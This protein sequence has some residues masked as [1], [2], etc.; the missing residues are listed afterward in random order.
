MWLWVEAIS[1]PRF[2]LHMFRSYSRYTILWRAGCHIERGKPYITRGR[3]V[4]FL[5]DM[6]LLWPLHVCTN[7]NSA[8]QMPRARRS[9]ATS[10]TMYSGNNLYAR[11]HRRYWAESHLHL[12]EKYD[13]DL[14]TQ[15]IYALCI[16]LFLAFAGG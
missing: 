3:S 7:G 10:R 14:N 6:T 13:H 2:K 12:A 1:E 11:T 5:F 16:Y 4:Y 9:D 8:G 15:L